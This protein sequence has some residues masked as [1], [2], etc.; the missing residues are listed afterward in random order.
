MRRVA[1]AFVATC[2]IVAVML[3]T[4]PAGPA[5]AAGEDPAS[6]SAGKA[7]VCSPDRLDRAIRDGLAK[8]GRTEA[9]FREMLASSLMRMII[10]ARIIDG[11]GCDEKVVDEALERLA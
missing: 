2:G 7:D 11:S 8:R 4:L 5:R 3:A 6:E 1:A 9:E 10:R